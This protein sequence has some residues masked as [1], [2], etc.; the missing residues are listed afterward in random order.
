M[1]AKEKKSYMTQDSWLRLIIISLGIFG[2]VASFFIDNYVIEKIVLLSNPLFDYIFLW[3][4]LGLFLVFFLMVITSLFMWEENKKDW[5]IPAWTSFLLAIVVST[6][7][8][9]IVARDRPHESI[10]GIVEIASF[11]FPSTHA[12]ASFSV[13]PIL[14]RIYPSLKWFWVI[15]AVVVA[16]SRLY[17]QVHFL[18][19]IIAGALIGYAIGLGV[20]YI[21][22]KYN[23]FGARV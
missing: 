13:V 8:K 19:D 12:A 23:L 20:L 21:K 15:F 9:L 6:L 5:V 10:F 11:A 14:D 3:V 17:F 18:S 16:F 2:L 7:L 1:A 4:T 22:Q